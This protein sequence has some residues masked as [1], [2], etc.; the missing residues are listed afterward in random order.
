VGSSHNQKPKYIGLPV[1]TPYL[2]EDKLAVVNYITW[3]PPVLLNGCLHWVMVRGLK[4]RLLIFD[5]VEQTFRSLGYPSAQIVFPYLLQMEET[6]GL[7][8]IDE[9]K[10][11]MKLWVL[12]DYDREAWSFKCQ[13]EVPMVGHLGN[14]LLS[15]KGDMLIYYVKSC[16]HQLQYD[17]NGKLLDEFQWKKYR[18]YI[19]NHW[20][21]E[22]LIRHNFFPVRRGNQVRQLSC[23]FLCFILLRI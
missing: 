9:S 15:Q 11:I 10:G 1:A 8:F 21:K 22:S 6:L 5:T 19:T 13:I 12:Q 7:N 3:H 20:F 14:T 2:H 17:E 23:Y 18:P 4:D 16:L